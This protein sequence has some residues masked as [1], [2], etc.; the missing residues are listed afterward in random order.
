MVLSFSGYDFLGNTTQ[1]KEFD[2][3][4]FVKWGCIQEAEQIPETE[5]SDGDNQMA[6]PVLL[7]PPMEVEYYSS[8][9][10]HP[11]ENK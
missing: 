1:E 8:H 7:Q 9:K 11:T 10:V 4:L 5:H 2:R 3:T 6:S